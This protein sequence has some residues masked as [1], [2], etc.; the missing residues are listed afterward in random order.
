MNPCITL[1]AQEERFV[2]FAQ[3]GVAQEEEASV[4]LGQSVRLPQEAH[5]NIF[6]QAIALF[7]VAQFAGG[8]QILPGALSAT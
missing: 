6:E 8:H 4:L 3:L 5:I 2:R 7:A 1:C